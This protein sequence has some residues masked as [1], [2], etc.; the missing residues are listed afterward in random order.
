MNET[1]VGVDVSKDRL[2]VFVRPAGESFWVRRDGAGVEALAERL[3]GLA[4]RLVVM[5][6]T[7]G[8]EV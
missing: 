5:E 6:A 3:A 2:D 4:P 7:G 8:F 1:F